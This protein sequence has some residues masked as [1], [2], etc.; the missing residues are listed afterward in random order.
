MYHHSST[1]IKAFAKVDNHHSLFYRT[2]KRNAE[3]DL[4][5]LMVSK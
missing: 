3:N 4:P 2:E 5:K 1:D